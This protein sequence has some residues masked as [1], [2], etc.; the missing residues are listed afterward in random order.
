MAF[1][2]E[3]LVVVMV[4]SSNN[5]AT[6]RKLSDLFR[7]QAQKTELNRLPARCCCIHCKHYRYQ[8][9]FVANGSAKFCVH[10]AACLEAVKNWTDE[11]RK[12]ESCCATMAARQALMN[13]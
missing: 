11:K 8:K 2:N 5:N 12:K 4:S 1:I 13:V 7:Q 3:T 9:N 10:L 6:K